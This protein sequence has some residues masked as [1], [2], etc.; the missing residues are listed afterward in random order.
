[1]ENKTYPDFYPNVSLD[2]IPNI[3]ILAFALLRIRLLSYY[4]IEQ[5]HI[6]FPVGS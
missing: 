1:M 6:L 2:Y 3:R 4:G 5:S